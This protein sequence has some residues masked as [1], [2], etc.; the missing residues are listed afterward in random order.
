MRMNQQRA[1]GNRVISFRGDHAGISEPTDLP[2]SPTNLTWKGKEAVTGNQLER[3]RQKKIQSNEC[4][5]YYFE[6]SLVK[7]FVTAYCPNFGKDCKIV[8]L[9]FIVI[10]LLS[11]Q[12]NCREL[13]PAEHEL[14]MT[15][16]QNSDFTTTT[17][18]DEVLE[19]MSVHHNNRD[20]M[21]DVL[22]ISSLPLL[23][24]A[25]QPEPPDAKFTP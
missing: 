13:R 6:L 19:M 5:S 25:K 12:S 15:E 23:V 1:T 17:T 10:V 24:S 4:I 3:E 20:H 22:L 8:V 11:L 2:Y 18:N 9:T 14:T 7:I 21:R 16:N